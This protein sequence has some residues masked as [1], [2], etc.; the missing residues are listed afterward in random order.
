MRFPLRDVIPSRTRP[1]V[2]WTCVA[3]AAGSWLV[4]AS[5]VGGGPLHGVLHGALHALPCLVLG[6][7]VEDQLGH[8]RHLALL[9]VATGLGAT[10]SDPLTG[11]LPALAAA[12]MGVHLVLFPSSRILLTVWV[13]V[14][15]IP[16]FFLMGC[17]V[18]TSVLLAVPLAAPA[19]AC[20]VGAASARVLRLHGRGQWDHFDQMR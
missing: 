19:L 11:P 9:L 16:A 14:V 6:E 10:L 8:A 18:F 1:L 2:T 17:W 4:A 7:T 15:E 5:T 12:T 20:V 3:L 13:Q